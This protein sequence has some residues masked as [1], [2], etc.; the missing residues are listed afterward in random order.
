[1]EILDVFVNPFEDTRRFR[2]RLQQAFKGLN[3]V[4]VVSVQFYL[5]IDEPQS[6]WLL[7]DE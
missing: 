1:M 7:F 4:S 5:H 3:V 2:L 6:I